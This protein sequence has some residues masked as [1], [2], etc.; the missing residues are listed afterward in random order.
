MRESLDQVSQ[1]CQEWLLV[2]FHSGS[3]AV[4]SVA[5][6]EL[7]LNSRRLDEVAAISLEMGRC[8]EESRARDSFM[9]AN[10]RLKEGESGGVG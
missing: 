10:H 1:A 6:L 9:S 8:F 3:Q 4:V 2:T 7:L 5:D